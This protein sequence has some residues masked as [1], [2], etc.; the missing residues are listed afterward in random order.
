MHLSEMRNNMSKDQE[1]PDMHQTDGMNL[2]IK[3]PDPLKRG[4]WGKCRECTNP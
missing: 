2:N 1:T 3:N 4:E